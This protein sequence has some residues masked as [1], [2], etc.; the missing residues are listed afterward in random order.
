MGIS[1]LPF[2]F[3][4]VALLPACGLFVGT[5]DPPS[6]QEVLDARAEEAEE[7]ELL[8]EA[9]T[10]AQAQPEDKPA[11]LRQLRLAYP[12]SARLAIFHQDLEVEQ[13][14]LGEARELAFARLAEERSGLQLFL[15]ARVAAGSEQRRELLQA[16]LEE[17]DDLVQAWVMLLAEEALAGESE[18][19]DDLL[20][21]LQD[22]PGSAMGWRLLAS[23]APLYDRADLAHLASSL[24]PWSPVQEAG[25]TEF[26]VAR[27]ALLNGDP[28]Q[29]LVHARR[30]PPG[31]SRTVNLQAAALAALGQPEQAMDLIDDHLRAEPDD[32]VAVFNRALLL[33]EYLGRV[34]EAEQELERFLK[35]DA[36][37]DGG[38]L[39]RRTQ[40]EF[41]LGRKP[42]P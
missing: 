25:S 28:E 3:A 26:A 41:W 5:P 30:L 1:R 42:G 37:G 32:A 34:A 9:W 23:L 29:A 22:H 33:R 12:A 2:A 21:L 19:L 4:L 8:R 27:R 39:L 38:S 24:E 31:A 40:A 14:G 20:R 13:V 36:A 15:C 6:R 16:A 18:G 17:D 7:W 35:L 11:A 10:L